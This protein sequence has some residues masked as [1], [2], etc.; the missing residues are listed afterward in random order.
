MS[1]EKTY[2]LIGRNIDYSFS[3]RYF[4]EKFRDLRINDSEYKNFDLDKIN[5]FIKID[6]S[7][8][9]GFNVT[10]PYK[11]KI[12]PFLDEI[13]EAAKMIGAVNTIVI[14]GDKLIG[15]NTDYIGF[16][17]S[18]KNNLD[19]KKALIM[20]TGGASKAIQFSLKLK[21]IK[22]D[23]VSRKKSSD[24][25]NYLTIKLKEYDLIINTSP[26]GTY[27]NI[28]EKPNINYNQI[29][30]KKFCYDLIYNPNKTMFLIESEKRGARIMNGLG[31]LKEQAEESWN[32]W[33]KF[34]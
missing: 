2:G 22:F 27:P 33:K 21:K 14:K 8:I 4:N 20:G 12:I 23:I 16:I 17:K 13:D 5:D 15:Y 24:Y 26:L 10:I 29:N 31:M 1:I 7:K 30:E 28:G 11:E 25:K 3:K 6:L 9:K 34:S 19:F 18:F 32:L